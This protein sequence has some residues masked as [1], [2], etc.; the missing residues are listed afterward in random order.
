MWPSIAVQSMKNKIEASKLIAVVASI[1]V[2][3]SCVVKSGV[4]NDCLVSYNSP[5]ETLATYFRYLYRGEG[6]EC[7]KYDRKKIVTECFAPGVVFTGELLECGIEYK[8]LSENKTKKAGETTIGNIVIEK[9]AVECIVEV[10]MKDLEKKI[11]WDR[12]WFLLQ[13]I[14][15][16]WKI[17]EHYGRNPDDDISP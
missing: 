9:E 14:D 17:L 13:E 8:I 11:A 16:K 10:K 5:A 1:L 12:F 15:G 6:S 2:I 3:I 7:K 4:K